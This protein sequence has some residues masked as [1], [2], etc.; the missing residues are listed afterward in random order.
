M[1][2]YTMGRAVTRHAILVLLALVALSGCSSIDTKSNN[3]TQYHPSEALNEALHLP[4]VQSYIADQ[5][6]DISRLLAKGDEAA[7][8]KMLS[9]TL[10][11]EEVMLFISR[12]MATPALYSK[13][14]DGSCIKVS[15]KNKAANYAVDAQCKYPISYEPPS[16]KLF[17]EE[18]LGGEGAPILGDAGSW[19][20]NDTPIGGDPTRKWSLAY[21]TR[22]YVTALPLKNNHQPFMKRV[23][24][25]KVG[26][27]QLEMRIYK[28]DPTATGLKPML[29][30]HGG[31]WKYRN[32]GFM[33]LES[34][35]SHFT[36]RGYVVFAPFYRLVGDV[37]HL[38]D[39]Q[40]AAWKKIVS[41]AESALDWVKTNGEVV[42]AAPDTKVLVFGQSA[43]AHLSGWLLSHR[44]SQIAAAML[45]YPPTD[46]EKFVAEAK[47][48][49]EYANYLESLKLLRD[50]LGMKE[51]DTYDQEALKLNTFP[52]YV[53]ENSPPI[54]VL[55][56]NKDVVVP[57]DQS[58]Q[59]CNAFN[60][61]NATIE[62]RSTSVI[63]FIDANNYRCGTYG[64][65]TR[66]HEA[67]HM[68]DIRCLP[69]QPCA[70]G[71]LI[72]AC[73]VREGMERGYKWLDGLKK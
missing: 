58:Q 57:A 4:H 9:S 72:G 1:I 71:G 55:H 12:K 38:T 27:C 31:S 60:P 36:D 73:D 68:L 54:F 29:A 22:L 34:E 53:N 43:G 41:D 3:V 2:Y 28:K 11:C 17:C 64:T 21:G 18:I 39:C 8:K 59:L 32:F 56:G 51:G 69:T 46:F 63:N 15:W 50:F 67:N 14:D 45:Y 5:Y 24:Y 66:M 65:L 7:V 70:A 33:G 10:A 44:Q 26:Q 23:R 48:G 61:S 52:H 40:N 37:Y 47:P 13:Q 49:G 42:G 62:S 20:P 19:K 25:K 35:I 6:K 16:K 30:I